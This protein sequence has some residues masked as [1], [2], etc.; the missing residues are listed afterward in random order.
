MPSSA[1]TSHRRSR[2]ASREVVRDSAAST[3]H[4][5]PLACPHDPTLLYLSKMMRLPALWRALARDLRASSP[6]ART[7]MFSRT[8]PPTRSRGGNWRWGHPAV[9]FGR[10]SFYVYEYVRMRGHPSL[11]GE[12]IQ[13]ACF[14]RP[15]K[16]SRCTVLILKISEIRSRS[17]AAVPYR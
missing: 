4:V 17:Y 6:R 3:S 11:C 16:R 1:A 12:L 13:N 5:F 10:G 2:E 9:W 15:L 8:S 14:I 7:S